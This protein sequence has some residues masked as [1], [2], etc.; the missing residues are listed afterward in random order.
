MNNPIWRGFPFISGNKSTEYILSSGGFKDS[1]D[2]DG[3][4]LLL[5]N[6]ESREL[7]SRKFSKGKNSVDLLPGSTIVVPRDPR[8]FDWLG[9]T[10]TITPILANAAIEIATISALLDDD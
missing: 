9:M 8:P 10:Q 7:S 5:P 6:G 3:L 2:K 1:A 4:F